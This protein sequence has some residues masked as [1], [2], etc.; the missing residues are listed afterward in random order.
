MADER[1][2]EITAADL[3][4]MLGEAAER[5]AKSA[6]KSLGLHD[7]NAA[8]DMIELRSL[9]TSWREV[10][11]SVLDAVVKVLTT[12]ILVAL[13]LGVGMQL[14]AGKLISGK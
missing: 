14:G 8:K 9:L 3:E 7:E 10:R 6:L 1:T 5:G 11:K 13:F 2:I 12:S 4:A